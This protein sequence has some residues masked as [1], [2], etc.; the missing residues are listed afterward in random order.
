MKQRIKAVL[1]S[2]SYLVTCLQV[3]YYIN[4]RKLLEF[5]DKIGNLKAVAVIF[6]LLLA[7]PFSVQGSQNSSLNDSLKNQLVKTKKSPT[8]YYIDSKG[9]RHAFP[10]RLVYE[11]WFGSD[12]SQVKIVSSEDI[13]SYPL[14]RNIYLRSGKFLIK[15]PSSP[16]VYF[17]D[18]GGLLRHI[19]SEEVADKIFGHMWKLKVRDFPEVFFSEYT[20]GDPIKYAHQYPDGIVYKIEDKDTYFWKIN[21]TLYRFDSFDDVLANG[22]SRFDVVTGYRTYWRFKRP[23]KGRDKRV[24]DIEYVY[25]SNM[26]VCNSK[27]ISVAFI[28]TGS[29][30]QPAIENLQKIV[31]QYPDVYSKA[32]KGLSQIVTDGLFVYPFEEYYLNKDGLDVYEVAARLYQDKGD[33]YD[34]IFIF[35]DRDINTDGNEAEFYIASNQFMGTGRI[36]IDR[37]RFFGS[38][39]RLKGAVDMG[40]INTYSWTPQGRAK[41]YNLINHE[42]L[43]LWAASVSYDKGDERRFDLLAEDKM[44]WSK[45]VSFISPLGGW[46]WR[47]SGKYG[48]YTKFTPALLSL[49]ST[50]VKPFSDLD[51]YLMGLVPYQ[52]IDDFYYIVPKVFLINNEVAGEKVNVGVDDIIRAHGEIGCRQDT[53]R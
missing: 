32:T 2:H 33:N 52:Y 53:D 40:N 48:N 8:I 31:D 11:S 22:Y 38:K 41:L 36:L 42:I 43:H 50:Y 47:E 24:F 16:K 51:L 17:V 45:W 5:M 35:N 13:A 30:N 3:L 10:N 29:V 39:G 44:H 7:L 23:I 20:I 49:S 27:K 15:V 34:F 14:G 21:D 25:Q 6:L 37:A 12:F 46:G 4:V 26:F 18:R 19:T 9:V 1:Q 28:Y